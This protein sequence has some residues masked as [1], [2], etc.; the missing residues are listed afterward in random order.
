[1]STVRCAILGAICLC[2][3]AGVAA[4]NNVTGFGGF[5]GN[6]PN[7][8][9]QII[10][11]V[12][13][14]IGTPFTVTVTDANVSWNAQGAVPLQIALANYT[15]PVQLIATKLSNDNNLLSI[16]ITRGFN[17]LTLSSTS[18]PFGTVTARTPTGLKTPI[19]VSPPANPDVRI[20]VTGSFGER[21]EVL[22]EDEETG[23]VFETIAPTLFLFEGP[24]GKIDAQL[25][26]KNDLGPIVTNMTYNGELVATKSGEPFV[27]IRQP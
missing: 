5:V 21:M 8:T 23:Y 26:Q 3:A 19:Q 9:P 13:G 11:K 17:I 27:V 6:T 25:T 24:K 14:T 2:L 1:M 12:L 16:Q 4:C 18:Q 7:T 20:G 22:I 10:F 15:P